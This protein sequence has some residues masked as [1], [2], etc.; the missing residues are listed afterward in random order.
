MTEKEITKIISEKAHQEIAFLESC[1]ANE[2]QY[3]KDNMIEHY[4]CE[5]D[6]SLGQSSFIN[7]AKLA[8]KKA[9]ECNSEIDFLIFAKSITKYDDE[10][11]DY[12]TI[13]AKLGNV[14]VINPSRGDW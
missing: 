1:Y 9:D 10:I 4:E 8:R 3:I 14:F 12:K 11:S 13:S 5:R 7:A 6:E 2:I